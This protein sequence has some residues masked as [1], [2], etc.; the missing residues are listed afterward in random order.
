MIEEKVGAMVWVTVFPG[1]N[2]ILQI[3]WVGKMVM[4]S[5]KDEIGMGK[6]M[7]VAKRVVAERFGPDKKIREDVG[8]PYPFLSTLSLCP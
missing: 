2:R 5:E 4:P 6:V 3:P 8:Y 1:L 7:G